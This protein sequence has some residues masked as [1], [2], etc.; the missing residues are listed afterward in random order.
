MRVTLSK[1]DKW[2]IFIPLKDID[3]LLLNT[4]IEFEDRLFLYHPGVNIFSVFR[5]IVQN[6]KSRKIVSGASTLTMQLARI[7]ERKPRTIWAKICEILRALQFE[8]KLGK[9]KILELYLNLAPY[10]GNIEGVG[11]AS[12]FY[13]GKLPEK[14]TPEQV[15]FLVAL[16]KNPSI[17]SD[18]ENLLKRRNN[19]LKRMLDADI[20]KSEAFK[21]ALKT[22]LPL[23]YKQFPFEAPHASDFLLEK[24]SDTKIRST[25]NRSIQ[26]KAENILYSYRGKIFSSGASNGAIVIIEN[27]T[28]RVRALVGSLDYW[29]RTINGQIKGFY[30]YRSPGSALKPFLYALALER[31]VIN[32]EMLIEDAPYRFKDYS[33]VNFSGKWNGLVKAE[34]ALA[35]SLN[36]PFLLILRRTGYKVFLERLRMGGIEEAHPGTYYGLPLITGGMEVRL[37]DLTNL[38]AAFADGGKYKKYILREDETTDEE[39]SIFRPGAV[40]LT[41]KA[42]SRRARPD[43]PSLAGFTFPNSVVFWKTGTSW[44]RRDAW[45][46]GFGRK[47]T[48]G[49]W[50]GNFSGEG[51][52]GIVGAS[53]A[54]PIMFDIIRSLEVDGWDGRFNW[55]K[56]AR[57]EIDYARVCAF[58]GYRAEENCRETKYVP[59]LKNAH[60]YKKCPFHRKFILEKKTGYRACPWKKYGTGELVEKTL[61]VFPP[62]VQKITGEGRPPSYAPDCK[63]SE[64]S[65]SLV[66]VSPVNGGTYMLVEGMENARYVPLMA[67]S[68]YGKIHWFLNGKF[69]GTTVSGETLKIA[70]PEGENTIVVQ[71]AA[72]VMKTIK[73]RVIVIK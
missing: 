1:D 26:K 20:I 63:I 58:S 48:V 29:D 68:S 51:S 27:E 56:E 10:G 73:F 38:Y 14:L 7:S 8:L 49:V 28:H 39:R 4:T 12:L 45:S 16:P 54:A 2:R 23:E 15:A 33:P 3:P 21:R 46:I 72:G 70:P 5:A 65:Y 55:E 25:I 71:D 18:R 43:A 32:P 59:V 22:P 61:L 69:I 30:A 11:A 47:Y 42:L 37:L 57:G 17:L 19:I 50:I 40:W 60:P 53:I 31:G 67:F 41:L 6:L 13:F 24:Y 34:D 64:E 44:G 52:K 9:K 66:V 62:P 36:I 35:Y